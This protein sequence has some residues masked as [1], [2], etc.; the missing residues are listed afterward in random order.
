MTVLLSPVNQRKPIELSAT[1]FR[2][3]ILPLGSI[4]YK[5][6][7]LQ[8]DKNYLTELAKNFREGAYDSVPFQLADKEN[9]H[10]MDPKQFGGVVK[11]LEL[12]KSGLDMIVDLTPETADLVRKNNR[13]GVSTQI[14]ESY[15]RE[16]DQKP[17]GKVVRHVLGTFDPRVAGMGAWQEVSLSEEYEDDDII[18]ATQEEVTALSDTATQGG[19]G[20]GSNRTSSEPAGKGEGG[21]T[22]PKPRGTSHDPQPVMDLDDLEFTDED[23]EG[24]LE[25]GDLEDAGSGTRSLS[26]NS[27]TDPVDLQNAADDANT[28][29]IEQLEISLANERFANE[30]RRFADQGIPPAIVELCRPI[31]TLPQAPV[32]DLS[33]GDHID[34]GQVMRAVLDECA[35]FVN[36]GQENGWFDPTADA[37]QREDEVLDALRRL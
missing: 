2:K 13:F 18:D 15:T 5:G 3:Q 14:L 8:F 24:L 29:R 35:G 30:A 19:T 6:R 11:A 17:F 4:K 10:T 32:I 16:A 9:T 28:R 34:V 33:N 20:G 22:Q 23:L 7:T 1:L 27:S 37:E 21:D 26:N 36:L 31:L 25:S 12:T